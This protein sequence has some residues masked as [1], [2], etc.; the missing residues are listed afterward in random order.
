MG[1]TSL[2]QGM[3]WGLLG[4]GLMNDQKRK[5][6]VKAGESSC[7]VDIIFELGGTV[8]RIIRKLIIKKSKS[9]GSESDFNE[10]AV[11]S[12]PNWFTQVIRT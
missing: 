9:S 8:Y 1:K 2:I 5:T 6:L 12:K 3:L 4:D 10:E 11:L 7:K